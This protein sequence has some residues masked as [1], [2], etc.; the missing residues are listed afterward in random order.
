MRPAQ[1]SHSQSLAATFLRECAPAP[2]FSRVSQGDYTGEHRDPALGAAPAEAQPGYAGRTAPRAQKTH[3]QSLPA[4]PSCGCAPALTFPR[5]LQGPHTRERTRPGASAAPAEAQPG[6]AGRTAPRA[7]KPHSQS[8][9][10]SP[11]CGYAPALTFP[12][13]LQGPYTRERTRPGA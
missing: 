12:R 4:S 11:S 13:A 5:A 2:T 6:F 9:P 8:L 3:S 10:A 1:A 7:Q